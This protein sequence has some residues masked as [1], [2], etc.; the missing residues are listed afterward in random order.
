MNATTINWSG[1]PVGRPA[2]DTLT[3]RYVWAV[4]KSLPESKRL[5][6]DRE[7]RASIA[8]DVD[9][10]VASGE[11]P[12]AAERAVLLD[13]GEPAR[14]AASYTGRTLALIGPDLYPGYVGLLKLLY[15]V[16]LPIATAAY[17]GVQLF[18]GTE[19]G[20]LI[21]GTVGIVFSLVVNLGFWTTL[22]FAIAERAGTPM[23]GMPGLDDEP[24]DPD[25]L[26]T[27]A[28]NTGASRT[29]LIASLVFLLLIPIALIWQQFSPIVGDAESPM[30]ILA[31]ALW[32]FWLP[33]LIVI[34]V[35]SAG[36]AVLIYRTGRW[37]W[38]LVALNAALGLAVVIPFLALV[39][40]GELFNP[41]FAEALGWQ[42]V[43]APGGPGAVASSIGAG[44]ILVWTIVD[45]AIKTVRADRL[46]RRE[47]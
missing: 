41:A 1:S 20:G 14:L 34:M 33:Y 4:L 31:P 10:R 3:D 37:T 38:P 17:F 24:F 42:A 36:F 26:P 46:L 32:S 7:L 11:Q 15:I 25:R 16:V 30:P 39:G 23:K 21:G 2:G 44:A 40:N 8:D 5:D 29:D 19:P 6:I 47:G 28:T 18:A 12:A 43:L 27:V 13:L 9:A 45:S 22:I 35:L